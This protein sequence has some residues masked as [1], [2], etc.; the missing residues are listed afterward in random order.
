MTWARRAGR[1]RQQRRNFLDFLE[2]R[3]VSIPPEP[4]SPEPEFV[5]IYPFDC[6]AAPCRSLE[7]GNW[8]MISNYFAPALT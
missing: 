1:A 8:H 2:G 6:P 3:D 4:I 7:I 5:I